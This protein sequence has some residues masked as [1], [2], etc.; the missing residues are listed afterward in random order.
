MN[1]KATLKST[2]NNKNGW[3]VITDKEAKVIHAKDLNFN[4]SILMIIESG[5]MLIQDGDISSFVNKKDSSK[6]FAVGSFIDSN[7]IKSLAFIQSD[8]NV[9]QEE[10]AVFMKVLIKM[11]ECSSFW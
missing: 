3:F 10:I 4:D 9:T 1:L 6:I 8:N 5:S 11:S 7:D 2:V